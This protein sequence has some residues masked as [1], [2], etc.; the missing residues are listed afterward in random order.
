M[1]SRDTIEKI[2]EPDVAMESE[3]NGPTRRRPSDLLTHPWTCPR[4]P[5]CFEVVDFASYD[6]SMVPLS[7]E[8]PRK[9]EYELGNEYTHEWSRSA[10]AGYMPTGY[11][12][13]R[14]LCGRK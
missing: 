6:R 5:D 7:G 12:C 10:G 13:L 9:K 11:L 4:S 8:M 1:A 3:Q 2:T 14:W